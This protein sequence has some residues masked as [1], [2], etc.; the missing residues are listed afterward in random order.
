MFSSLLTLARPRLLPFVLFLPLVG[1][2]WA[3]WDRALPLENAEEI[4]LLFVLAGWTALHA[5][6]LWLNAALDRDNG[7]VLFGR[8]APIPRGIVPCGLAALA[9]GVALCLAANRLAGI[10]ALL[11]AGLAILYSHPAT[12]WK[13]HPLGG[14]LVNGAGYGLLSPLAGWAV[15]EVGPNL[16]SLLVWLLGGLGVLGCY[17]AAQAFQRREDAAR[18]YRT[19][20]VTHGPGGVL[21]ATRICLGVGLLGGMAL[22]AFGWL[23]RLCLAG[24]PLW[25]WVDSWLRR[26]GRQPDGGSERWA[27]GL[28]VRLLI[29]ALAAIGVAL[30]DYFAD[31]VRLGPVAGLATVRGRPP[32]VP[33]GAIDGAGLR[34]P[35]R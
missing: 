13:G 34:Q 15:A 20:I 12:V 17:F 27:R 6:A 14:P 18:G 31:Q 33:A 25:V 29:S 32:D 10:S 5:G 7:E 2:G 23:P 1:F 28:A 3:H 8:A 24:V 19:L 9:V 22:A 11:C 4:R 21:A 16:R 30:V 26:W 35:G